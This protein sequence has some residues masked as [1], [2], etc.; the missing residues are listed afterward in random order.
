MNHFRGLYDAASISALVVRIGS[1][2]AQRGEKLVW[3]AVYVN[4]SVRSCK[5]AFPKSE[6]IGVPLLET[7]TLAYGKHS[8]KWGNGGPET[9]PL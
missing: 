4:C 9:I 6:S 8:K 5:T 2:T 7:R 3:P 1:P